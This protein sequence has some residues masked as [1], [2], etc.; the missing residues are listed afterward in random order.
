MFFLEFVSVAL[1][2]DSPLFEFYDLSC[3]PRLG[4][5]PLEWDAAFLLQSPLSLSRSPFYSRWRLFGS[6]RGAP[7]SEFFFSYL[8]ELIQIPGL[9]STYPSFPLPLSL[10]FCGFDFFPVAKSMIFHRDSLLR[11]LRFFC[12][13]AVYEIDGSF[14]GFSAVFP[15]TP[16]VPASVP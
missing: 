13:R 16:N 5:F 8:E 14:G 12:S 7:Q 1:P 10:R 6:A 4:F 3:R 15:T 2:P 11:R 9:P